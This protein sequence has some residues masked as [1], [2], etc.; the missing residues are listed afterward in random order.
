MSP[1]R[2]LLLKQTACLDVVLNARDS[3]T[4]AHCARVEGLSQSL[5]R[6]CGLSEGEL[7]LLRIAST[8]HDIGKI[9]IPDN[10]LLKPASL[11]P[12]EWEIMKTHAAIGQDFCDA[13]PH[14]E[15]RAVGRIV[16]HH[17]E[18]FN[19]DGYPDGLSGE[20]IPIASRIIAIVDA[21]D[22]MTT[23]RPYHRPRSHEQVMEVLASEVG[24][25]ADPYVFRQF[26]AVIKDSEYR[27]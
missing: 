3:Y 23:T 10:I 27:H 8:L 13:M 11:T 22:A 18:F 21:Y 12:D 1:S 16:R 24:R 15:S 6:S 5:G 20:N 17:H 19:G 26:E 9:G 2:L 25:R 4:H 7:E 14:E